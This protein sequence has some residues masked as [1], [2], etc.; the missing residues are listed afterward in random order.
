MRKKICVGAF[1]IIEFGLSLRNDQIQLEISQ[2]FGNCGNFVR[3]MGGALLPGFAVR[4]SQ[5]KEKCCTF[6]TKGQ[7]EIMIIFLVTPLL[8][9]GRLVYVSSPRAMS[10][11]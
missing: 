5:N 9:W 7:T 8:R 1:L 11:L 6:D 3:G 2:S 4:E 10:S